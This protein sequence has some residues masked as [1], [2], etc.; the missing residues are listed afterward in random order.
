M[1]TPSKSS[2]ANPA[3]ASSLVSSPQAKKLRIDD[4]QEEILSQEVIAAVG[5]GAGAGN[6]LPYMVMKKK[7]R[8]KFMTEIYGNNDRK[9]NF[10]FV[11]D[12]GNKKEAF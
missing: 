10:H 1:N 12:Y 9:N 8:S 3:G 6:M 4:F 11:T 2:K 7:S 5:A